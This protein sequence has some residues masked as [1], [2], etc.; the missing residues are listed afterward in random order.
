[1][2]RHHPKKATSI[3][4]AA[5]P[6]T[7]LREFLCSMPFPPWQRRNPSAKGN[8]PEETYNQPCNSMGPSRRV[9]PKWAVVRVL[10]LQKG[11][12]ATARSVLRR[13]ARLRRDLRAYRG[14]VETILRQVDQ[15]DAPF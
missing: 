15:D 11:V 6:T 2:V 13:A 14:I 4:A 10:L 1:M 12:P 7:T 5:K 8:H 9:R 3:A